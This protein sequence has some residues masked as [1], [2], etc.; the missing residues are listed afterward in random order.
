MTIITPKLRRTREQFARAKRHECHFAQ[1]FARLCGEINGALLISHERWEQLI[2][3]VRYV[4]HVCYGS[5]QHERLYMSF[6]FE[7]LNVMCLK[8]SPFYSPTDV[9][10]VSKDEA[11]SDQETDVQFLTKENFDQHLQDH[12]SVL[13]MFYAPCKSTSNLDYHSGIIY[14][15]RPK[16]RI[17]VL[18]LERSSE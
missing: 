2:H 5:K 3:Q 1:L 10:E 13:V 4:K 6:I 16:R 18:V 12:H 11:W 7:H 17:S 8:F 14:V 15:Q 9:K